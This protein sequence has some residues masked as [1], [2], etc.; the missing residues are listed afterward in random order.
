[1][2]SGHLIQRC[3]WQTEFD[4]QTRAVELQN[5]ISEWSRTT[6]VQELARYFNQVCPAT[7]TW[8]IDRLQLDLGRIAYDELGQELPRRLRASLRAAFSRLRDGMQAGAVLE[9]VDAPRMAAAALDGEDWLEFEAVEAGRGGCEVLDWYLQH[10]STP[11]WYRGADSVL[12]MWDKQLAEARLLPIVRQRGRH[13][14]VRRRMVWQLGAPRVRALIQRLEPWQG[15]DICAFADHLFVLQREERIPTVDSAAFQA[16]S[17]CNILAFLFLDR[18]SLFNTTAFVR[19]TLQRTAQQYN[20]PYATLLR[21]IR[22]ALEVLAPRAVIATP[23]LSAMDDLY[24]QD[25]A[26]PGDAPQAAMA[27]APDYW[28]ELQRMLHQQRARR[29]WGAQVLRLGEVFTALAGEDPARMARLLCQEGQSDSVRLGM[30][31]LLAEPELALAAS[32]LAPQQHEFILAHVAHTRL[33]L[34]FRRA[35][36]KLVWQIVLTYLLAHGGSRFQRKQLVKHSVQQVC[37]RYDLDTVFLLDSLL[38]S[39]AR[40]QGVS[41]RFALL[42]ICLELRSE[43]HAPAPAGDAERQ[44]LLHFLRHGRERQ[45]GLRPAR[46]VA[47]ALAAGGGLTELC[48]LLADAAG[49]PAGDLDL[50]L[51]LLQLAG[52]G[53]MAELFDALAPGAGEFGSSLLAALQQWHQAGALPCLAGVDLALQL[54]ALMVQALPGFVQRRRGANPPVFDAG[55]FWA[56]FVAHLQRAGVNP[57]ALAH[58]LDGCLREPAFDDEA[59]GRPSLRPIGAGG[60]SASSMRRFVQAWRCDLAPWMR[61]NLPGQDSLTGRGGRSG[62]AGGAWDDAGDPGERELLRVLERDDLPALSAWLGRQTCRERCLP[63]LMAHQRRGVVRQWLQTQL[64][65]QFNAPEYA[66]ETLLRQWSTLLRH[67][68]YWQGARA[69]LERQLQQV[70]WRLMWD[71]GPRGVRPDELL[72][73]M[74]VNGCLRLNIRLSDCVSAFSGQVEAVR[75]TPWQAALAV[76]RQQ[77]PVHA[78]QP[79]QAPQPAHGSQS[80]Q[81][82]SRGPAGAHG[83]AARHGPSAP[84]APTPTPA[85]AFEQD[86]LGHYLAH[87][88]LP[89]IAR[90]LLLQGHAPASCP[91][92]GALDLQRLLFDMLGARPDL[93]RRLLAPL[94]DNPAVMFRVQRAVPLAWLFDAMR[95]CAPGGAGNIRL[96]GQF[97]ACLEHHALAEWLSSAGIGRRQLSSTLFT[98][99][100]THWLAQDDAALDL[101]SLL[102]E[103][104]LRLARQYRLPLAGLRLVMAPLL[105][106]QAVPLQMALQQFFKEF[107]A[108]DHPAAAPRGHAGRGASAAALNKKIEAALAPRPESQRVPI[109][110]NNA[111]LVILQGF[112]VPYLDRLGLQRQGRF[113]D[114]DAQRRA[115]HYLQ[116]LATGHH[117]TDEHYLML[118]KVLCGLPLQ[119]PVE[120]GI[121]IGEAEIKLAESLLQSV[122][123]YW[124]DSGSSS[125]DGLRGNWLVRNGVLADE[126]EHWQ[127]AVERRPYDVLLRRAT[128]SYSMMKFPWME[129]ALHVTW[130]T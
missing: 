89:A 80:A 16:H 1:M 40:M 111:G 44:A 82:S 130:P 97:Q 21:Q 27:R 6:L 11:W 55:M 12:Q 117:R 98:L 102:P 31:H 56:G 53:H 124:P 127:L 125:V 112:F 26:G 19:A 119:E 7:Q 3:H 10:G 43:L 107:A 87:P 71:A 84:S 129:K 69:V 45:A 93:A 5:F 34:P 79:A 122:I 110:V 76:L 85:S 58:Q 54:P 104:F 86:H 123:G 96:L 116:L 126:G 42:Q 77:Q 108:E 70:F 28:L 83:P 66:P 18:G 100:L 51:R 36:P 50:S 37:R 113:K 118:N 72:A 128:F 114:A 32:V 33:A 49:G 64:P 88:H 94:R 9:M 39:A 109:S 65:V 62:Q 74:L 78:L 59:E 23:F 35:W 67:S 8:R 120:A 17:W 101:Q 61:A 121:E 29:H 60:T 95:A 57:R 4:Q 73:R 20:L 38:E 48:R 14:D 115:V 47:G 22:G 15:R 75:G 99:V 41:H 105:P 2:D 81:P 103:L 30:V 92:R 46:V 90:H 63:L 25:L 24:R 68:G 52:V 106:R 91:V 13:A